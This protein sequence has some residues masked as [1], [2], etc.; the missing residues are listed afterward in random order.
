M[1]DCSLGGGGGDGLRGV[2]YTPGCWD[3]ST[4]SVRG[5]GQRVGLC[6]VHWANTRLNGVWVCSGWR[7][8]G[9]IHRGREQK[10]R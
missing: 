5:K 8:S 1:H 10:V 7:E 4:A 2:V 3:Q 9:D 6:V